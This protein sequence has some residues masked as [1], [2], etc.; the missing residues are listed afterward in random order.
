MKPVT[1]ARAGVTAMLVAV[2]ALA[3][4]GAPAGANTAKVVPHTSCGCVTPELA[5]SL[6]QQYVDTP[7][8]HQWLRD[9]AITPL[10]DTVLDNVL[11]VIKLQVNKTLAKFKKWWNRIC[12]SNNPACRAAKACLINFVGTY[13]TALA[14]GATVNQARVTALGACFTAMMQAWLGGSGGLKP[15]HYDAATVHVRRA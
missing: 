9:H 12:D 3:I 11:P 1:W 4:G 7:E 13:V 8:G 5:R 15:S 2:A 14:A 10:E 6:G